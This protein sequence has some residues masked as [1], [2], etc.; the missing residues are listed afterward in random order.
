MSEA[1][2]A[3]PMPETDPA[4]GADQLHPADRAFL[5]QKF[6]GGPLI[7]GLISLVSSVIILG[8]I[9]GALGLRAGID[10]WQRGVR[11]GVVVA[12][13]VTSFVGVA[14]SILCALLWG[15]ILAGVLLGRD[16][17]RETERWRGEVLEPFSLTAIES[18]SGDTFSFEIPP[19]DDRVE[20]V[21]LLLAG[22]G[23]TPSAEAI[24]TAVRVA[25]RHPQCRL[26]VVT[27]LAARDDGKA[28]ATIASASTAVAVVGRDAML[29]APMNSVS[30]FP[31]MVFIDRTGRIEFALVGSRREEELDRL[32]SGEAARAAAERERALQEAAPRTTNNQATSTPP[33]SG[34]E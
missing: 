23:E 11:R 17:M 24:S 5:A 21:V 12:G 20:R 29:P 15:S 33:A 26:L 13:V 28:F 16:A 1:S 10:L 7:F 25:E 31:T 3:E 32:F 19:K 2:P 34:R 30:A 18:I 27:P 8:M 22:V 4:L 9:P 14:A 6:A